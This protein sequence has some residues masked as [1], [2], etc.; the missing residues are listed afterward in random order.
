MSLSCELVRMRRSSTSPPGATI[1][2]PREVWLAAALLVL[3]TIAVYAPLFNSGFISHYDDGVYVTENPHV[4]TGLNFSNVVWAFTHTCGG[5]WHP[6][7]MIS[8][9]ADCQLFGLSPGPQHLVNLVFHVLNSLLLF[10][11]LALST[12]RAWPSFFVAGLFALHPTHVESVAWIAERKDVLSTFFALTTILAYVRYTRGRKPAAYAFT[13]VFFAAGLMSKPMLV[14]LPFVL[15]LLDFWPL[16]RLHSSPGSVSSSKSVEGLSLTGSVIEKL[17]FFPL[18]LISIILTLN[19][20]AQAGGVPDVVEL[21]LGLRVSNAL[22]AFLGYVGKLFIPRDLAVFYPYP[23]SIPLRTATAAALAM[24][25]ITALLALRR[26]QIPYALIGW[27]WFVGTLV[28]VI[29]VVQ[30]GSQSMADRYTYIPHIG[31][32]IAVVWAGADAVRR[33]SAGQALVATVAAGV[34]LTMAVISREQVGYW[35]DG[36]HL[37]AHAI[38]VTHGNFIAYNNYGV[39]VGE[40]GRMDDALKSFEAAVQ[41]NPRYATALGNL[42]IAY[43]KKRMYDQAS[44]TLRKALAIAPN[45][46]KAEFNLAI[47]LAAEKKYTE[48]WEH[49]EAALRL[50]PND[51]GIRLSYSDALSNYGALMGQSGKREDA[52]SIFRRALEVNPDN[53]TARHNL[54]YTLIG[55]TG[56]TR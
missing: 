37:F 4:K 14:T 34:L 50:T 19:A 8:H 45:D 49:Y 42:G 55:S 40:A 44:A 23:A 5:N 27:L 1:P 32:Y 41:L 31:L 16:N 30:A 24:L 17:P 20:Q 51:R 54:E 56:Q 43:R 3:A 26:K 38:D 18:V 29:G 33:S 46:P 2:I 48:A 22:V 13:I 53:Q 9:M 6:L 21:P 15:V 35:K 10:Y 47:V 28:P 25:A 11:V 7:T 39:E 36:T 52:I 12:A